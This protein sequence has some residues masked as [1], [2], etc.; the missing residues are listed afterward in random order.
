MKACA[1][2]IDI[3][4]DGFFGIVLF[5][6]MRTADIFRSLLAG[7]VALVHVASGADIGAGRFFAFEFIHY[8]LSPCSCEVPTARSL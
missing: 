8:E 2:L 4:I 5:R 1:E 3:M 7:A 6:H